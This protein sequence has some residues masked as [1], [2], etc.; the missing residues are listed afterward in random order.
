ML[1]FTV[2]P[3]ASFARKPCR[4]SITG[5]LFQDF[6]PSFF[7]MENVLVP[8][9]RRMRIQ[10]TME[11]IRPGYVPKGGGRLVLEVKPLEEPLSPLQLLHQGGTEEI[12]GIALSSHLQKERVSQRMADRCQTRL[13]ERGYRASI[14]AMQDTKAIQRGA[15]LALWTETDTGCILG[16]DQAG[17][18]GRRSE[19]ISEF[20]VNALLEDIGAGATT[21]RHL[22]DQ[23]ILFAALARGV[24]EYRIPRLTDHV[25]ANLWLVEKILGVK[26]QLRENEVRVE[27]IGLD[28]PSK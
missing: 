17:K 24:T 27:G 28:P 4:F 9:V 10:A 16:A 25:E 19:N 18:P 21:D 2:L 15:A 23:L 14:Q 26:A 12:R 3:L 8:L 7:H 5:G 11:M 13:N 6:A 22:A 1:A 20:V